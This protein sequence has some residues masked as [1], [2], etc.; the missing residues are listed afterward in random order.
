MN[1]LQQILNFVTFPKQIRW[2]PGRE[3]RPVQFVCCAE[4][5]TNWDRRPNEVEN[6][7]NRKLA[8]GGGPFIRIGTEHFGIESLGAV[9]AEPM[10]EVC[11]RVLADVG[12][13]RMPVTSFIANVFA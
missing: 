12:F 11:F 7:I 6:L 3:R 8:D 5:P 10:A 4:Q 1:H 2:T 13:H 9:R